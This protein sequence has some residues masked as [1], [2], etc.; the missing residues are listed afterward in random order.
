MDDKT[1][2]AIKNALSK[3][4]RVELVQQKDGT[5]V[6]QTVQRRKLKI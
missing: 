3:G 1:I 5:I 2:Q 4:F 6:I